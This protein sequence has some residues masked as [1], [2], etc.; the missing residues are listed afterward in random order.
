MKRNRAINPRKPRHAPRP[1][2]N[3]RN[4]QRRKRSDATTPNAETKNSE[5]E[6]RREKDIR[7]ND[8]NCEIEVGTRR[9]DTE[10]TKNAGAASRRSARRV[11]NRSAAAT[12][13]CRANASAFATA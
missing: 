3:Q 4:L 12:G 2:R 6:I 10:A 7:Q 1:L 11:R 13:D 9:G 8:E 5:E